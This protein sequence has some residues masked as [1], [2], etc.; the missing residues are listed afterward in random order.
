MKRALFAAATAAAV[1]MISGLVVPSAAD[2]A[3]AKSSDALPRTPRVLVIS[4]PGV[5]WKDIADNHLPNL[6]SVI[7]GSA[8]AD[9][10]VRVTQ[11]KT[12]VGDGYATLSAGTRAVGRRANAG[13]AF[14]PSERLEADDA[15]AA[16]E[17]QHGHPLRG[18]AAELQINAIKNANGHTLYKATVA[19]LGDAL[20]KEGVQRGVVANADTLPSFPDLSNF[21]REAVAALM[22][23]DGQV[24]CGAV[25]PELLTHGARAAFGIALDPSAV[26]RAMVRC[27]QRRSV[28]L[29]EGSDL[30]RTESYA[31]SVSGSQLHA[32]WR[33]ALVRTDQLVGRLLRHV[34]LTRDAIVLVAPSAPQVGAPHLTMLAVRAPGLRAGLLDSGVTRQAGFV[35]IV[36]VAPTIAALVGAPLDDQSIEGRPV[37]FARAGG[38]VEQRIDFLVTADQNAGFRDGVI[39]PFTW[40][41]VIVVLLF[42]LVAAVC[43][44]F[45]RSWWV[46]EPI[47]L[48]LI[49]T[50]PLTYWAALLPFRD[51]PTPTYYVFT[52][53]L[54]IAIGGALSLIFRRGFLPLVFV[55]SFAVATIAISVVG[56][57]SRL[58]LSTVFGDSPV[59]AGRFS[60]VNNTTFSLLMVA[61]ILLAVFVARSR[62]RV[63]LAAV[64]ALFVAV[65]LVD[66]APMWGSDVGG[67]LAGLPA[68]GLTFTLLAGWR[69]RVR[70][71]VL[72]G[73]GTIGAVVVLGL[74]DLTRDPSHRTH[75]GRLFEK[76]GNQGSTGFTTVVTRKLDANLATLSHSV[77]RFTIA[78]IVLLALYVSQRAPERFAALELRLPALRAG[79][80]GLVAAAVLGY[81]LNDSG[82]AIPG[83][84][85]SVFMPA[86]AFLLIRTPEPQP[87]PVSA[88]DTQSA[89]RL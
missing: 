60:G 15:A 19:A 79:L 52:F 53:G 28:V 18:A 40:T 43:L 39:T 78:P 89:D 59:V 9:L 41:F 26:E 85:L 3:G 51:W 88:L 13:Q 55:L 30:A 4:L 6:R 61:T 67:V 20:A 33:A 34:D 50:L 66:G 12:P 49:A 1:V 16:Y 47:A 64:A 27:W 35:S 42:G 80:I 62:T 83:V 37:S 36:D 24:P 46:I 21:H 22:G 56:L 32:M 75:L 11:L 82:I 74:L 77:W 71:V 86:M 76:I 57:D 5:T 58:Q 8:V 17:R 87:E 29:V 23:S 7:D 72:W 54:G 84:M 63:G 68:F 45:R 38:N 81:A 10:A 65:A 14:E 70:T 44:W 48:G 69:V 25:G 31:A 2:A 73:L